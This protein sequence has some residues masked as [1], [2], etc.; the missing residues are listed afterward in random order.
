ME[1]KE[2]ISA[3]KLKTFFSCSMLYYLNYIKRIPQKQNE[4]AM[5]GDVVH[6]VL[7]CLGRKN[8]RDEVAKI[9]ADWSLD[10][11]PAI[12][13]YVDFRVRKNNLSPESRGKIEKFIAI[14]VN[15]DFWCEGGKILGYEVDFDIKNEFPKYRIKGFIDMLVEYDRFIRCRDW[16]SQKKLFTDDELV[17]HIQGSIYCLAVSKMYPNK[18][19]ITDFCMLNFEGATQRFPASIQAINSIKSYLTE[20][21]F[22]LAKVY[23][24][25]ENFTEKDAWANL[26]ANK[27]PRPDHFEGKLICGFCKTKGELKK[28]GTP[29]WHCAYRFGFDY[30]ALYGE[31]GDLLKTSLEEKD[32]VPKEGETVKKEYFAGCPRFIK[33]N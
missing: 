20:L 31:T 25:I 1:F 11:V 4:G 32:L 16:K 7:E 17:K 29:K 21:E 5:L 22:Y 8:R 9:Q 2:T 12:R 3:S 19:P 18:I 15:S 23:E 26:A 6:I 28:D 14:A 30:Y 27:D 33:K 24:K 13:R 10:R